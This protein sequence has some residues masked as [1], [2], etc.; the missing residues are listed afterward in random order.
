MQEEASH[1][2]LLGSADVRGGGSTGLLL[3]FATQSLRTFHFAL[4][5]EPLLAQWSLGESDGAEEAR[6]RT[7]N[8]R[9][10]GG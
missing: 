8:R 3:P 5:S 7:G 4:L 10:E 1:N 9:G 6:G 2:R